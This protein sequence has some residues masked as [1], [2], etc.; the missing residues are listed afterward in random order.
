VKKRLKERKREEISTTRMCVR[1]THLENN[2][3]PSS[4]KE[5]EKIEIKTVAR[6]ERKSLKV[7]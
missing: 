3:L 7:S 1:K 6:R 5:K 2:S 4:K